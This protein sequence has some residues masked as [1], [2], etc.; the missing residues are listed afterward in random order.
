MGNSIMNT[1]NVTAL[2]SVYRDPLS[3]MSGTMLTTPTQIVGT[4]TKSLKA[5]I[6]YSWLTGI[7]LQLSTWQPDIIGTEH[8]AKEK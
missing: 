6:G 7:T 2:P 1:G 5:L 4:N 3:N 8:S